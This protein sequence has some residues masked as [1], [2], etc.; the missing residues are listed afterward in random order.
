MKRRVASLEDVAKPEGA[1]RAPKPAPAAAEPPPT[2][3][4]PAAKRP[5]RSTGAKP[6]SN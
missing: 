1:T 4:A 5:T 3:K 2:P 6:K